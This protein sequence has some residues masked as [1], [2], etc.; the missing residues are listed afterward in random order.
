MY[1]NRLIQCAAAWVFFLCF[2]VGANAQLLIEG[3][4]RIRSELRDGAGTLKPVSNQASFFTSQRARLRLNYHSDKFVFQVS[5]QDARVWGED[6][7]TIR[8]GDGKLS[9]HEAWTELILFKSVD[10]SLSKT[11]KRYAGI[12]LGRQELLYDDSRLLGNLD[13]LQQARRHDAIIFKFLNNGWQFDLGAAFNQNTDAFNYNGTYYT[14]A[15]LPLYVKDSRG[16]F[17]TLPP[18][19]VPLANTAGISSKTGNPVLLN[20][21]GTNS[22]N[23]H[24]KAMEFLY[25]SRQ[26]KRSKISALIF[27]DQF[28]RYRLDSI[29]T[30]AGFDTGYIYGRRYNKAGVNTRITAGVLASHSAGTKNQFNLTAG[31]Y[32][33]T[34]K[35]KDG[36]SLSAYTTTISLSYTH[37]AITYTAGWDI[38]S[39]NDAF[40]SS[41]TSHRFDPLYGT[42][43]RFWGS[44]DYFYAGTGSPSGGLSNPYFKAKYTTTNKRLFVGLDYH[45]FALAE[46]QKDENGHA[47]KKYLGSEI[48]LSA[49]YNLNK[50][51][52]IEG[53]VCYL[54]ATKSMEYA[55]NLTPRTSDLNSL[56][57]YVQ[58][59]IKP[60]FLIK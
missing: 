44:M 10:S 56:W 3:Q 12:K 41:S 42:P 29:S 20:M 46:R 15:N 31:A 22:L 4:L 16:N 9:I 28:S 47:I 37:K 36:A 25:A 53:A 34:G 2:T 59:N 45:Y 48:D 24:Y 60:E 26:Y 30:I 40:S 39:G 50:F 11:S 52:N 32:Y 7:S 18:G 57:A 5:V 43:H 14:P 8:N 17:V 6:A 21:P 49:G 51:V 58:V 35:D 33:Q 27:S 55:K 54:A 1:K 23:Q 13:W 19:I 38:L